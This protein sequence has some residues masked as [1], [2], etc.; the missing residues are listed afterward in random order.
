M[1]LYD[2]IKE[3]AE[4][5]GLSIYKIERETG[6]SNGA[7]SKWNKAA[8]NSVN[9]FKVANYLGVSAEDLLSGD[10]EYKKN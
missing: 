4:E 6:L 10:Q 5:K 1:G 9:L 7:I 3:L 2:Q 8:P